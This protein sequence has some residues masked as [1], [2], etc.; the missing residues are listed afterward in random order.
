MKPCPVCEENLSRA[1]WMCP[2]CG[3]PLRWNYPVSVIAGGMFVG[4]LF[5]GFAGAV[6]FRLFVDLSKALR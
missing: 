4:F 5:S 3:H 6:L 1:A 2:Y